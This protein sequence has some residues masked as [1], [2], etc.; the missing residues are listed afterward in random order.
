MPDAQ[1]VTHT[2]LEH[3]HL[4]LEDAGAMHQL[5]AASTSQPASGQAAAMDPNDG[6]SREAAAVVAGRIAALKERQGELRRRFDQASEQLL[7]RCNLADIQGLGDSGGGAGGGEASAGLPSSVAE[8]LSTSPLDAAV[9]A[10][11]QAQFALM[12]AMHK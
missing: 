4:L 6:S 9:K 7:G 8:L 5:Q 10:V 11:G 3:S 1:A 2:L 12:Q